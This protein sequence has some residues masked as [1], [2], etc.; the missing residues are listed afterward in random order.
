MP[1]EE[2][3][4]GQ[5]LVVVLRRVEHHLDDPLHHPP[6]FR[7]A[8]QVHAQPPRDRRADFVVVELLA[9]DRRRL[10][11]FFGECRQAR[12]APQREPEFLDPAEMPTLFVADPGQGLGQ[13]F[14]APG[15][16]G[17][18][19]DLVNPGHIRRL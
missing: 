19:A 13:H 14:H 6:R 16:M 10:H 1:G 18:V 3:F 5:G 4:R 9:L 17:P 7:Q 12:L 8:G 15:E 11:D 2:S